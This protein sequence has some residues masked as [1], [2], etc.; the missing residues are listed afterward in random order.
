MAGPSLKTGDTKRT[1]DLEKEAQTAILA[2][3]KA[4]RTASQ[5]DQYGS[6]LI[7]SVG[8]FMPGKYGYAL[9]ATTAALDSYKPG[10]QSSESRAA[11]NKD[12]VYKNG[13]TVSNYQTGPSF[14]SK[15]STWAWA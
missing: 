5:I 9:A 15:Q 8:L 11:A 2:D 12:G 4:L 6:G 3:Q 10:A 13:E 7:K 1:A 14:G